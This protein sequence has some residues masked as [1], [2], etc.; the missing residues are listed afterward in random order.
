MTALVAA[1]VG[2]VVALGLAWLIGDR[3]S[4]QWELRRKYRELDVESLQE[5]YRLYGEFFALLKLW[6][7]WKRRGQA[8]ATDE[9]ALQQILQRAT[10]AEGRVEA[11]LLKIASER[12]LDANQRDVLG[13]FRQGYQILRESMREDR[14]VEWNY[15]NYEP[16]AAFK[17]L[18]CVISNLLSSNRPLRS[19]PTSA[20][21][22][23]QAFAQI[24]SHAY[25]NPRPGRTGGTTPWMNIAERQG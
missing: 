8:E 25:E 23:I 9:A 6:D 3:L 2:P 20:E 18:A 7:A 21:S 22:S 16:Y 24:T 19:Q 4:F 5:F 10:D 15:A 12:H 13:A 1:V 14:A 17:T 11:L